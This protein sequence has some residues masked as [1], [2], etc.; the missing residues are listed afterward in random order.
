[1]A[2][3]C[4]FVMK[5]KG[6]ESSLSSFK[7]IMKRSEAYQSNGILAGLIQYQDTEI[8]NTCIFLSGQCKWS[9]ATSFMDGLGSY[10]SDSLKDKASFPYE[11]TNLVK[12]AKELKLT[13]EVFGEEPGMSFMEYVL[14][15]PE[16]VVEDICKDMDFTTSKGT[17]VKYGEFTI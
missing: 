2:N 1:M 12:L 17:V 16:E 10:Y 15:T 6:S 4:D 5:V 9:I 14:I 7:D 8:L 13:I 11:L 3:Y